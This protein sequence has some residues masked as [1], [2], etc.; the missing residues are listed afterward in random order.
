M[1][2]SLLIRNGTVVD[3]SGNAPARADVALAGERIEAIAPD[4]AGS[5]ERVIDAK[6]L[7]VCPGFID[8][9]SHSDFY[10]FDCP[11]AESKVRQGVTTEV[12]GMCSFSP[13]PAPPDRPH[14]IEDM[15]AALGVTL[16]VGWTGFGEYL[17]RLDAAGLGLNVVHFVGHGALRL[18]AMGPENRPAETRDIAAM[19][20]LLDDALV[21]GAFGF[22]SGLIYAPSAFADTAE[23]T[24]LARAMKPRGGL[25]FS[26]IRGEAETLIEAVTEAIQIGRDAGVPVQISHVKAAGRPHWAKMDQALALIDQARA[27]GQDVSADVYPY[28]ASSTTMLTLLPEWLLDG[29]RAR[30]LERLRDPATRARILQENRLPDG[31]WRTSTGSI[32]WHEV[33]IASCPHR[34]IEG[35]R[36]AQL[37]ERN[38]RSGAET[39]LDLIDTHDTAVSMVLFSQAEEN[40]QKALCHPAIMVG[41]DS[42]GLTCGTGPHHGHPHPRMYGTFPRVLARYVRELGLLSWEQAIAKMTSMPARRLK[43]AERGLLRP[44]YAADVTIFDPASVQDEATFEDPHRYPAGITSVIVNGQLMVHDGKLDAQPAGRVLRR[45]P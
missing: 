21:A 35:L 34:E 18:A 43:L 39:M 14:L 32:A 23:L 28:A 13:A 15:A 31:S 33:M 24:A 16:K 19:T 4:L 40:V 3:G 30:I 5:A 37:A 7:M 20:Q 44:G 25:Y 6:G 27:A 38:G 1:T 17:D 8:A 9:H 29:G 12:V 36:I 10:Y 42:I 2:W 22:S 26:H 41:S 45:R 11:S